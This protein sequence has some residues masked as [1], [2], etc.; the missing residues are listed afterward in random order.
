MQIV[1]ILL[2]L[3][4]YFFNTPSKI[5][6]IR[7]Y[8]IQQLSF[9]YSPRALD[10]KQWLTFS[11]ISPVLSF[12]FLQVLLNELWFLFSAP[13]DCFSSLTFASTSWARGISRSLASLHSAIS[14]FNCHKTTHSVQKNLK[15][16]W[17]DIQHRPAASRS[18]TPLA[19]PPER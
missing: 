9:N 13:T 7:T 11:S 5:T 16:R 6:K 2:L 19:A 12:N 17:D 3:C 15:L 18:P 1:S 8:K 4:R 14:P 10:G